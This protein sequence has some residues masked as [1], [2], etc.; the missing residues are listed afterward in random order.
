MLK[1]YIL[2]LFNIG[3]PKK[4]KKGKICDIWKLVIFNWNFF[5]DW[6]ES[7]DSAFSI[8][9]SEPDTNSKERNWSKKLTQRSIIDREEK[10]KVSIWRIYDL[11]RVRRSAYSFSVIWTIWTADLSLWPIHL[12]LGVYLIYY[13]SIN[14]WVLCDNKL[15]K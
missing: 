3:G 2:P 5:Q 15:N 8:R 12:F 4:L 13:K 9:R 10:R 6:W 11:C 14:L 7:C 1:S